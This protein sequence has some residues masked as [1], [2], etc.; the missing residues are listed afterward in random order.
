EAIVTAYRTAGAINVPAHSAVY[1]LLRFG[2]VLGPDA[3]I[4]TDVP[5]WRRIRTPAGQGWVN[6]NAAGVH[7]FSD[8]D[9]PHWAGWFLLQDHRDGDSRCSLGVVRDLLDADDDHV[10]TE[11]EAHARMRIDAVQRFMHGIV[12]RFPSEWHRG[13]V[14]Q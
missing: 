5:H 4:P 1:E 10:T 14:A 9:A 6:L 3:L 8:A 2:R 12:A 13:S 11:A 7:K